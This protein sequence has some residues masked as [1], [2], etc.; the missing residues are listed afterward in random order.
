[1]VAH[2][3]IQSQS[4]W[5]AKDHLDRK[6][7]I[8]Q[9]EPPSSNRALRNLRMSRIS[10]SLVEPCISNVPST[11]RQIIEVDSAFFESV[12]YDLSDTSRQS[13]DSFDERR[14][15]DNLLYN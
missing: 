9:M 5:S 11:L 6:L 10:D 13:A 15:I 7:L 1:T 8:V 14:R 2:A 12:Q 4:D 3:F